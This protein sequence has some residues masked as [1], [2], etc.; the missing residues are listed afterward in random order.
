MTHDSLY[1]WNLVSESGRVTE[2][3]LGVTAAGDHQLAILHDGIVA[4]TEV[5]GTAALARARAWALHRALLGRG[6]AE[7]VSGIR[8]AHE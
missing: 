3:H 6:W 4:A 8:A 5:Y 2:C 7:A 1:L